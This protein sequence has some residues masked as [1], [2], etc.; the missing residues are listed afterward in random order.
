MTCFG[1]NVFCEGATGIPYC[2][3]CIVG[4]MGDGCNGDVDECT[5]CYMQMKSNH[6]RSNIARS[7]PR[8]DHLALT[9]CT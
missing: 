1:P 8:H 3:N 4:Y 9:C 2:T 5:G 6:I 7:L